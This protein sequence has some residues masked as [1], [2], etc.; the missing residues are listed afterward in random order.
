[1]GCDCRNCHQDFDNNFVGDS[2][3]S[4]LSRHSYSFAFLLTFLSD[5]ITIYFGYPVN[6]LFCERKWW[7]I[8]CECNYH[9]SHMN[10]SYYTISIV[11]CIMCLLL[12][13]ACPWPSL[14]SVVLMMIF[15]VTKNFHSM[16]ARTFDV[17]YLG[18]FS[19]GA[20][21]NFAAAV[22]GLENYVRDHP[23][24]TIFANHD[25]R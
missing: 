18:A 23:N 4:Y 16:V 9:T 22:I 6:V 2:L 12:Q 8:N 10:Q 25:V 24:S 19:R 1:M 20:E 14:G 11:S 21:R 5:L 17:H 13:M 7:T 3:L 15:L